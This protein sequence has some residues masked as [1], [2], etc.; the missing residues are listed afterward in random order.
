LNT[1]LGWAN[2]ELED[3]VRQLGIAL[4]ASGLG[5]WQHNLRKNQTQWD[6]QLHHIYDVVKGP[7][8]VVWLDSLHPD[9]SAAAAAIFQEAIVNKSDY[10]SEFR[11]IC[12]D[13]RIKYIR[14]R[15]KYFIDGNGDPCFIGAELDVTE[16]AL[17]NQQLAYEREAAEKSRS[18]ARYAADHDYLTGLLNRRAFDQAL[19]T[20]R[21]LDAGT[22][23]GLCHVDV[24]RFKEINDRFGHLGGDMVLRH[25]GR[26]L[27]ELVQDNEVAVRLGGDEFAVLTW[28]NTAD[29]V[30]EIGA[31]LQSGLREP[32]S[33]DGHSYTVTCSTGTATSLPADVDGLLKWSDTALYQAKKAGRNRIEAFSLSL[34]VS[35]QEAKF[36]VL[37]LN[38]AISNRDIIPFYQIQVDAQSRRIVGMEALARWSH[39]LGL[40]IPCEF[41]PLAC[42]HKLIADIDD[43]IL[44][45]VLEDIQRWLAEGLE[46]PRVSVNL[47]ATRLQDPDL[48][49]K[50]EAMTIPAGRVSFELVETIFLDTL[51]AQT[52]VNLALIR[53]L[54]IDVEIDDLGAGHASLVG[55]IQLRPD[56]VKIDRQL[57]LPILENEAQRRLITALVDIA[58]ALQIE[59][60]AEGVESAAHADLLQALGVDILQGYVFSR[61]EPRDAITARLGGHATIQT[62]RVSAAH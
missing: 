20:A 56:R 54:G 27:S 19:V 35:L 10:A 3:L 34:A 58:R 14:S 41:L 47:S 51:D 46:V 22:I 53:G 24:D 60:V 6:E 17:R 39:P 12:P 55:L 49:E 59:V 57:V 50:L 2:N 23:V 44:Q 28:G 32:I 30:S 15:A 36:R 29:R 62:D 7:L 4:E 43:L 40:R 5:I 42:E 61:P 26:I 11:I 21:A 18:E 33:V 31:A 38:E 16:D 13:G 25:I 1:K 8:D 52:E 37:E 48:G 9:D 45:H